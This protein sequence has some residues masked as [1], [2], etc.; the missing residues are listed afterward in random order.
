MPSGKRVGHG[1]TK[2]RP[3][4]AVRT[5]EYRKTARAIEKRNI[6]CLF[7]R[8]GLESVILELGRR[9]MSAKTKVGRTAEERLYSAEL[10]VLSAAKLLHALQIVLHQYDIDKDLLMSQLDAAFDRLLVARNKLYA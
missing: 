5:G 4:V 2:Q 6:A 1:V 9:K 3:K 10:D 7:T 8:A